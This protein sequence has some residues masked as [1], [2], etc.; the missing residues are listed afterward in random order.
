MRALRQPI[1]CMQLA[2]GKCIIRC[3]VNCSFP[4]LW[5]LKCMPGEEVCVLCCR[6][7]CV[8]QNTACCAVLV[9]L[10]ASGHLQSVMARRPRHT[11]S[12]SNY[13]TNSTDTVVT[14]A[15]S[16]PDESGVSVQAVA[17]SAVSEEAVTAAAGERYCHQHQAKPSSCL[18]LSGTKLSG[19]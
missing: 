18:G 2:L 7:G 1:Q 9:L 10:L 8:L 11:P 17:D 12:D 15:V 16:A 6:C 5:H 4:S 19:C 14:S 3:V 13:S